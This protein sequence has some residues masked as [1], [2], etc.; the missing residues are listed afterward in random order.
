M[1]KQLKYEAE[2]SVQN[3]LNLIKIKLTGLK[4]EVFEEYQD[5]LT[6]E[7]GNQIKRHL[8]RYA[9]SAEGPV[10]PSEAPSGSFVPSTTDG[11]ITDS[12]VCV[13]R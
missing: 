11:E 10:D 2:Q 5:H 13:S 6:E 7:E 4:V 12:P 9:G 3:N 1:S 8:P